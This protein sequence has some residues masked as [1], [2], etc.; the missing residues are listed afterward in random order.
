MFWVAQND[1]LSTASNIAVFV[2]RNVRI[3]TKYCASLAGNLRR[4]GPDFHNAKSAKTQNAEKKVLLLGTR[5]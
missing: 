2:A 5:E 1:I 3:K 4:A